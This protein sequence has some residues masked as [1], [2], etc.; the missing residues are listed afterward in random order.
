MEE[1]TEIKSAE[2]LEVFLHQTVTFHDSILKELQMINRGY[3]MEN[4]SMNMDHRFDVKI[5]FQTQWEPIAFKLICENVKHLSATGPEEFMGSS[6]K[7]TESPEQLI[8]LSLDGEFVIQCERLFFKL[9]PELHGNNEHLGSQ[10]PSSDMISA[11][12]LEKEWRQ[13]GNCSDAWEAPL[14]RKISTCPSCN[15]VTCLSRT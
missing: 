11:E 2:E 13:C 4:K 5:L 6:G 14:A 9:T 7:F 1:Y 15:Q 3:V 10:V 12:I 8:D